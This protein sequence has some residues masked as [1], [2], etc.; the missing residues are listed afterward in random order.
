MPETATEAEPGRMGPITLH[1]A[2]MGRHVI[3]EGFQVKM[4][5]LR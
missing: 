3:G 4:H 5:A 2:S 1:D